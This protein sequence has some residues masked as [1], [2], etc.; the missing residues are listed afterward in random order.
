MSEDQHDEHTTPQV[1]GGCPTLLGTLA[2]G[3][4]RSRAGRAGPR[5]RPVP[6][7]GLARAGSA[8]R[9]R[10]SLILQRYPPTTP[11][12]PPPPLPPS[13]RGSR[14][15]PRRRGGRASPAGGAPRREEVRPA[16]QLP[17]RIGRLGVHVSSST[18]LRRAGPHDEARDTAA[19]SPVGPT[20]H[21]R[22]PG[23]MATAVTCPARPDST[24]GSSGP[25]DPYPVLEPAKRSTG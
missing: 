4:A 9:G 20:S 21:P 23:P 25:R 12:R 15:R 10:G 13:Q 5:R 18:T 24:D 1:R 11:T 6:D 3:G 8:E 16:R 17:E 2:G 14:R 22:G 7:R 19:A